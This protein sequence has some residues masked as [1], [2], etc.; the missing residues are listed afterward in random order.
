MTEHFHHR[1]IHVAFCMA[2]LTALLS[3][4]LHP[5]LLLSYLSLLL[6][7][8]CKM[9]YK[10]NHVV[11]KYWF[12]PSATCSHNF[13]LIISFLRFLYILKFY[14]CE[15]LPESVSLHHVHAMSLEARRGHQTL[16]IGVN[17][18]E[19]PWKCWEL[20]PALWKKNQCSWSLSCLSNTVFLFLSNSPWY[21]YTTVCS[22]TYQ[23][24]DA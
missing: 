7:C 24:K 2:T 10:W 6:F 19:L 12:S 21:R 22:T 23:L 14:V 1:K 13:F 20:I 17:R 18:G 5:W 16:E 15:C 9:V 3:P 8:H 4:L 11:Y